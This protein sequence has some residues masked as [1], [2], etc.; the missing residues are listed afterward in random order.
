MRI[1]SST[2]AMS[3]SRSYNET[4]SE[5]TTNI[6]RYYGNGFKNTN[7]AQNTVEAKLTEVSGSAA[8]FKTSSGGVERVDKNDINHQTVDTENMGQNVVDPNAQNAALQAMAMN[9]SSGLEGFDCDIAKDSEIELLKRMLGL[10]EKVTGHKT[11]MP[12]LGLDKLKKKEFSAASA[13]FDMRAAFA[14]VSNIVITA[15]QPNVNVQN[16]RWTRQVVK[17]GFVA[18]EE[19]TAFCSKGTV[20]TADGRSIDFGITVE[21][22]HSF[23]AAYE[24]VGA[25]EEFVLT[26]PLVINLDTDSAEI[27]DVSFYFDLNCDGKEEKLYALNDASGFLALDKNGDGKI[28]NGSELFGAKTGDGFSELSQY[29]EDKNGWI[30]ENDS[31][32]SSLAVWIKSGSEDARLIAL[33]KAGVGAIFLGSQN[34]QFTLA[35]SDNEM[36]AMAR[37][38]GVYLNEDGTVGTIQHI[39]FKA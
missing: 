36:G 26:D 25:E 4:A 8:V 34:T 19:N 22:S 24:V 14:R 30:D 10:I 38:T 17:S 27:S 33:S 12:D 29:D 31:V 28:N 5:T 18:G 11:K 2:I 13:Q 7:I 20:V 6:T 1:D 15:E 37:K 32:F 23:V 16:G 9:S 35:N 21:M 39:D 3:A